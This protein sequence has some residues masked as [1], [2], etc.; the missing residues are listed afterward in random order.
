MFLLRY[1]SMVTPSA[2]LKRNFEALLSIG[3]VLALLLILVDLSHAQI[4][5]AQLSGTVRDSSGGVMPG[6]S[7]EAVNEK[8]GAVRNAITSGSGLFKSVIPETGEVKVLAENMG[9]GDAIVAVGSGDY[10]TT[11]WSGA[12]FYVPSEGNV[13]KLLDTEALGENAADAC[14]DIAGQVLYLPTFFKNRVKAYRLVK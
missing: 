4:G 12:V 5:Q 7:V 13:L 3:L 14:F 1:S 6:V 10:I 8:T 9:H 11:N 2:I